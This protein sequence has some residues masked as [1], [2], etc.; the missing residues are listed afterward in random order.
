MQLYN[1]TVL[2]A[3]DNQFYVACAVVILTWCYLNQW[4]ERASPVPLH[5]GYRQRR[6]PGTLQETAYHHL[7][8]TYI[9]Q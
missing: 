1:H 5:S 3:I 8:E 2:H 4:C 9:T 6:K 7:Q